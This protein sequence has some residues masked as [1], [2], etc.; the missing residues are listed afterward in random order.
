MCKQLKIFINSYKNLIIF[1]TSCYDYYEAM[2]MKYYSIGEF[3]KLIGK[4]EQTK[5]RK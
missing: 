3:A 4:T 2:E 5:L 1:I